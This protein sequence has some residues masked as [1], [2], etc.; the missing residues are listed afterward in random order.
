MTLVEVVV[1]MVIASVLGLAIGIALVAATSISMEA[2]RP[3]ELKRNATFALKTIQKQVRALT[4]DQI[5]INPAGDTLTLDD[6]SEHPPYFQ[7][8][9]RNLG[10]FDG[11]K[12]VTLIEDRVESVSFALIQGHRAQDRLLRVTLEVNHEDASV[13]MESLTKLRN[14]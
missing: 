5:Q 12:T 14:R 11:E 2:K 6:G 10:F 3:L 8:V 1:A 13:E 4:P 9:D 7:K